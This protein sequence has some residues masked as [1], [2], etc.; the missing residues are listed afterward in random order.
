MDV[1][2]MAGRSDSAERRPFLDEAVAGRAAGVGMTYD[3]WAADLRCD[4]THD[5]EQPLAD[6]Y[7]IGEAGDFAICDHHHDQVI[8]PEDW[9]AIKRRP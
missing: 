6:W 4:I 1:V 3:E 2:C 9:T 7:L 8:H 5:G